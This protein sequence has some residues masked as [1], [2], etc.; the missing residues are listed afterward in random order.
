M[1]FIL[2]TFNTLSHLDRLHHRAGIFVIKQHLG[3]VPPLHGAA[4][5]G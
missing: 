5:A 4:F 2:K 3:T 1:M